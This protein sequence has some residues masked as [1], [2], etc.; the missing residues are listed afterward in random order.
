MGRCTTSPLS[1]CPTVTLYEALPSSTGGSQR[2]VVEGG[3]TFK[4]SM[5]MSIDYSTTA[6]QY[7]ILLICTM[8]QMQSAKTFTHDQSQDAPT[9]PPVS[10]K[11]QLVGQ[12]NDQLTTIIARRRMEDRGAGEASNEADV[13][14]PTSLSGSSRVLGNI[15]QI[16]KL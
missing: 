1:L 10:C 5:Q 15:S 13:A 8:C 2:E 16:G 14:P 4:V 6:L 3:F 11:R 7:T 12:S 9:S